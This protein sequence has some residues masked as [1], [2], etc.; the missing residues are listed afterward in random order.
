[1]SGAD[2]ERVVQVMA[3]IA[4]RTVHEFVDPFTFPSHHTRIQEPYDYYAFGQVSKIDAM[5]SPKHLAC[6]TRLA[7]PS[8]TPL[9]TICSMLAAT[10]TVHLSRLQIATLLNQGKP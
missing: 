10:A 6:A 3:A 9:V 7:P 5:A 1:M 2:E 4:D 8:D